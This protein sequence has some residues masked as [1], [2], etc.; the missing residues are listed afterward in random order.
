[1][2][3]QE[4]LLA[5]EEMQAEALDGLRY[6]NFE[7]RLF[8]ARMFARLRPLFDPL[9]PA[10]GGIDPADAGILQ[11]TAEEREAVLQ[12]LLRNPDPARYT[13]RTDPGDPPEYFTCSDD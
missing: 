2:Q 3:E 12:A 11:A 8:L 1:L 6:D 10:D 13:A 4:E 7:L 9:L 5:S